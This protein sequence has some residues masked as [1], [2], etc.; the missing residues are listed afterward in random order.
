MPSCNLSLSSERVGWERA[1]NATHPKR[2]GEHDHTPLALGFGGCPHDSDGNLGTARP[3]VHEGGR[4]HHLHDG[5]LA[6]ACQAWKV[7]W[8]GGGARE[9]AGVRGCGAKKSLRRM[10]LSVKRR[11]SGSLNLQLLLSWKWNF[12]CQR[13]GHRTFLPPLPSISVFFHWPARFFIRL[14]FFLIR[15]GITAR[16]AGLKNVDL[17]ATQLVRCSHY[18]LPLTEISENA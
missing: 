2:N 8:G 14:A 5:R 1:V 4:K 17:P 6:T 9:R 16:P 3:W 15:V 10:Q 7:G 13:D 12:S 11:H 18:L